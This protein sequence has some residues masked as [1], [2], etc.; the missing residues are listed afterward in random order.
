MTDAHQHY[1]LAMAAP[2]YSRTK[3]ALIG[4]AGI[5]AIAFAALYVTVQR[6]MPRMKPTG[7]PCFSNA[8]RLQPLLVGDTFR[9][10]I[11]SLDQ[12]SSDCYG[13]PL[14]GFSWT[15]SDA[16]VADVSADG[17]VQA[18]RPGVFTAVARRQNDTLRTDG[19]VLPPD[20]RARIEPESATVRV[21]DSLRMAMRPIDASGAAL[22]K[23]PF[24]I[25][26]PEFFDP[27][28]GKR[29]IVNQSSWQN[30]IEPVVLVARDTGTTVLVG[31][32]GFQQVAARI[33][34]RP[35]K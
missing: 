1:I 13:K 14:I 19:F 25:F 3:N 28:A 4:C 12:T 18:K 2:D 8:E 15:T 6:R 17:V 26:T 27:M 33:V 9:V 21:G 32:I 7:R 34:I 29:P 22:P 20:W 30:A 10:A 24:S 5:T 31:R 16:S 35:R 23:V 11:R